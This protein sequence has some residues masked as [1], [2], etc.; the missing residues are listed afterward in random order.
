MP[1][2]ANPKKP[3]KPQARKRRTRQRKPQRAPGTLPA[4]GIHKPSP[5]T[6]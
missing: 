4:F 1:R 6:H 5:R 2:S 3:R